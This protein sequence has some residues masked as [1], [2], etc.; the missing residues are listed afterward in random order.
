MAAALTNS[1]RRATKSWEG[2]RRFLAL[3][4]FARDIYIRAGLDPDRVWVKPNFVPDPGPRP[5]S[6]SQCDI[7]LFVGRISA[8]KGADLV[9]E[10]WEKAGPRELRLVMVGEGPIKQR[11]RVLFP[12]VEFLGWRERG[13]VSRRMLR[14]RALL[15]PSRAYEGQSMVL[16]EAMAAGL[17]IMASDWPPIRET[18][19]GLNPNWLREPTNIESW[20]DGLARIADDAAIDDGGRG[21]RETYLLSFTPDVGLR[22]L[23]NVYSSVM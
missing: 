23:E 1:V 18:L 2:V 7:V 10:A 19:H 8:E 17:P 14:A 15:F 4:P 6:P 9:A 20:V 21:S 5:E 11:L 3:T 16:L 13:E 22:N 12:R